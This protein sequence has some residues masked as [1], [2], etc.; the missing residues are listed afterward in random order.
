MTDFFIAGFVFPGIT[1]YQVLIG[2]GTGIIFGAIWYAA[3]WTNILRK[4]WAWAILSASIIL[5]WASIAF[6]QIPLQVWTGKAL[7]Y[8]WS[9]T[10]LL[11]WLLL[12]GIPQILLSGL[13]QEGSK[14]VPVVIF[15]WKK[16][17]SISPLRGLLIGAVAGLGF[18]VF[19]A[20]W[21][22]LSAL[23]SGLTWETVN[24]YGMLVLIPF[25]ERFFVIAFH[26]AASAIAGWGLARGWGW[27][28]YLIASFTHAIIN[29][30]AVLIQSGKFNQLQMEIFIITWALAVTSTALWL[31]YRKTNGGQIDR[32]V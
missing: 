14:L 25:M 9:E 27:Q 5:T 2:T 24:M 7:T 30:S 11:R 23:G 4:P 10:I 20:I 1:W 8:F 21:V 16:G 12:A 26:T 29:Y 28:F 17:K 13:V 3:Y 32:Q 6:I 31:R 18:G 22:H 15:W 19:E